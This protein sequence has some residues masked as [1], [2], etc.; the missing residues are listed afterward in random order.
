[1]PN[2]PRPG[3]TYVQSFARGLS[4]IQAF[5]PGC[6]RM[7]LTEVA[8]KT[9]LTRAGARRILLTLQTLGFMQL[10][11]RLFSL[12]T[13]IREL[14]DACMPVG[15]GVMTGAEPVPTPLR[16][17]D[18]GAARLLGAKAG[19]LPETRTGSATEGMTLG[20]R[21]EH[22][23]GRTNAAGYIEFGSV[24]AVDAFARHLLRDAAAAKEA[25]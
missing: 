2:T 22:V 14:G 8:K 12:T 5:G 18:A 23:G 19:R 10:D 7:T 16:P 21:I 3:D 20:E 17:L 4:V 24:M 13:K 15:E 11:G 25:V 9:K 1:M 6:Q